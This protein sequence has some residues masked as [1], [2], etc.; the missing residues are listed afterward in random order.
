MGNDARLSAFTKERILRCRSSYHSRLSVN[1]VFAAD[2]KYRGSEDLDDVLPMMFE[3]PNRQLFA[4]GKPNLF[5]RFCVVDKLPQRA[6]AMGV[7]HH[8][9]MHAEVHNT[10]AG[11]A[12]AVKLV[13]AQL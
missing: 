11:F 2:V 4:A 8:M 13:E 7:A 5:V 10:A 9:G 6:D 1:G 12:F 3:V